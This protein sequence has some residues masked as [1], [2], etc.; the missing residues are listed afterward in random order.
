M[1]F[2]YL[3]NCHP[4]AL[5]LLLA[6]RAGGPGEW[7][8][9]ENVCLWVQILP[10]K[11]QFISSMITPWKN[12]I[13]L[14]FGMP[15]PPL[16]ASLF[17]ILVPKWASLTLTCV[18]NIVSQYQIYTFHIK[19]PLQPVSVQR[20]RCRHARRNYLRPG[21]C[22]FIVA[23]LFLRQVTLLDRT[24]RRQIWSCPLAL[25]PHSTLLTCFFFH[26]NGFTFAS[27]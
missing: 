19:I 8:P 4:I 12:Q 15:P 7:I 3:S 11:F 22:I 6:H 26:E 17:S 1:S 9:L 27:Y 24:K 10:W 16:V 23:T 2:V 14:L 5:F 25:P 18:L 20:R 21:L 13:S